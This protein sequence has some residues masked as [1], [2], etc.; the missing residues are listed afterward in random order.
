MT[1]TADDQQKILFVTTDDGR[2]LAIPY[3]AVASWKALLGLDSYDEALDTIID[4]T[5]PDAKPIDWSDKYEALA[6]Q[7]EPQPAAA[8]V[9][10]FAM[11]AAAARGRSALSGLED[12]LAG[13]ELDF[14]NQ[15]KQG[16][17]Q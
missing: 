10:L 17:N 14:V 2:D 1:I 12:V 3:Q 9:S 15:V 16:G 7:D 5:K 4:H 8:H 6:G 13:L 11:P